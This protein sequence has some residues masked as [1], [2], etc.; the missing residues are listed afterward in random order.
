M[1]TNEKFY[2]TNSYSLKIHKGQIHTILKSFR[3]PMFF[4]NDISQHVTLDTNQRLGHC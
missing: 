1:I 3:F 2:I 4:H